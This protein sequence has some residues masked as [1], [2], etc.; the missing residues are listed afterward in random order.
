MPFAPTSDGVR[1]HY[2]EVGSG[3]PVLFLHEF[4]GDHRA[5]EPQMRFLSRSN[6]CIAFAAR[7]YPPSDVPPEPGA[8]SQSKATSDAVTILDHLGIERAHI[9]GHSMGAYTALHVG[10]RHPGRCLSLAALGC[11]WGS[12]PEDRE[13]AALACEEIAQLFE[14]GPMTKAAGAYARAAMRLTFQAKDPRGFAE[15]ERMLQQHSDIGSAMTMRNI[16]AK[17]P[18]LWDMKE[19]LE[20]LEVPLL[21]IVGDEDHPCL[22]GSLF[23]KRVVPTAG[24]LVIPRSGHTI[25]LEEPDIVSRALFE[26]F[27][28]VSMGTWLSHRS[29]AQ[30]S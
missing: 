2:E 3:T 16:Q 15:F 9:V 13:H 11:G 29:T 21:V 6:R 26:L 5:W 22:D 17:R 24:L 14:T 12:R 4:A 28:A 27:S 1:L 18:T 23:L 8:Y 10:L 25:P 19:A 7:G 30:V 20:R